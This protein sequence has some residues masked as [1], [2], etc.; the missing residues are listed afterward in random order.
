MLDKLSPQ[1]RHAVILLVGAMLTWASSKVN[2]IPADFRPFAS[3]ALAIVTLTWTPLTHQYG[4]GSD[5]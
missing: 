5:E 1:V 2:V 3:A 4:V